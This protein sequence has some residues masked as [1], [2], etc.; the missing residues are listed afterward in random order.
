MVS[1]KTI[2]IL[3]TIAII[4]SAVSIV[5]TISAVNT[6]MVPKVQIQ[7]GEA[8]PDTERGHVA[9]IVNTPPEASAG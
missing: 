5:V 3:I 6:K 9:I 2:I 7:E 1:E 8:I 4:V